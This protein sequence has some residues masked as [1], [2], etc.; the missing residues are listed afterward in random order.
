MCV[1]FK[2]TLQT[3]SE[4]VKKTWETGKVQKVS[5]LT[6]D[7]TWNIVLF[8]IIVGFIGLFFGVGVGAGYFAALVKDE[9]IRSYASMEKEIGRASCRERVEDAGWVSAVDER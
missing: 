6:Y 4:K 9:P 1:D 7:I 2:K 3:Y 5:R 8:F